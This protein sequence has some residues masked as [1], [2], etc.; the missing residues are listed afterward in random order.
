[1]KKLSHPSNIAAVGKDTLGKM[2]RVI[3]NVVTKLKEIGLNSIMHKN[4][5]PQDKTLHVMADGLS[6]LDAQFTKT[7]NSLEVS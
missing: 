5:I 7:W 6:S 4:K 3:V 2:N 1:M